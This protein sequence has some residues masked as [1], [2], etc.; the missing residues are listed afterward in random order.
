VGVKIDGGAG[1]GCIYAVN[2]ADREPTVEAD[3]TPWASVFPKLDNIRK[4]TF[5]LISVM[6]LLTSTVYILCSYRALLD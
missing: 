3:E 5:N 4:V 1:E 2:L 6:R